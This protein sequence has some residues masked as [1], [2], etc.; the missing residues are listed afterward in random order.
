MGNGSRKLVTEQE[1]PSLAPDEEPG[2][3]P[4]QYIVPYGN[5]RPVVLGDE[6]IEPARKYPIRSRRPPGMYGDFVLSTS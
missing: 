2:L 6:I 1:D 5:L 4:G 3:T